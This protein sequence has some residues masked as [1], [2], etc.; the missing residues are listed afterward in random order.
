MLLGVPVRVEAGRPPSDY[1]C[2]VV[3]VV[4]IEYSIY[5]YIY[6]YI[7]LLVRLTVATHFF[8]RNNTCCTNYAYKRPEIPIA[9]KTNYCNSPAPGGRRV[10]AKRYVFHYF[11][12][13]LPE[14]IHFSN[15]F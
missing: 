9:F 10:L 6:I 4:V 11:S 13:G 1:Y 14:M 2:V 5:L 15:G 7:L 12:A 3:V 8:H